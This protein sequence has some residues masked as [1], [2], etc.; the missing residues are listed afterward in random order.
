MTASVPPDFAHETALALAPATAAGST[1]GRDTVRIPGVTSGGP[2]VVRPALAVMFRVAIGPRAD[3]YVPR[4]LDF[5]R[6]GRA[7][8]GWNWPA[9]AAPPV[10]AFY[11]RLWTEGVAFALLP[12]AGVFAF[13]AFGGALEGAGAAWWIA[14]ASFVW[15]LPSGLS[16]LAADALLWG[17]TR[18]V[19]AAA[20]I[21]AR[22]PTQA[23]ESLSKVRPTSLT[24][25]ILLGGGAIV[26]TAAALGPPIRSEYVAHAAREAVT[27]ALASLR[28]V[29]EAVEAARDRS[30]TIAHARNVGRELAASDGRY[31][32][33]VAVD[34]VSGRVRVALGAA[35]PGAAGK[36][37]VLAPTLDAAERVQWVCVPIDI[38]PRHLPEACRR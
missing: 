31:V 24:A 18:R 20:E 3:R 11:R 5:E 34:A 27:R 30:G 22:S 35:V 26:L 23:V 7:Q 25:A 12:V 36:S 37:I 6:A 19:V 16:A 14:L 29:Q 33:D 9:F 17:K 15:L 2:A 13:A 10:W 8:A 21:A 4:F 38:L 32:G 1:I 28:G